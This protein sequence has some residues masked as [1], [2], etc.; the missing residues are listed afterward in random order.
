MHIFVTMGYDL[1]RNAHT[2]IAPTKVSDNNF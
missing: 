1:N 2:S